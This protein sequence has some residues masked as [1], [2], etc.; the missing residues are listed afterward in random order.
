MNV[1]IKE[2]YHFD[3]EVKKVGA[4]PEA[5]VAARPLPVALCHAALLR[6]AEQQRWQAGTWAYDGRAN[7]YAST[8][9]LA[10]DGKASWEGDVWLPDEP[11]PGQPGH[12][13]MNLSVTLQ[14]VAVLDMGTLQR[15][16]K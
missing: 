1:K 7:V 4:Q 12:R 8:A 9:A 6:L 13:P 11:G 3:V 16:L 2:M 14:M 15:Y 10:K 5:G